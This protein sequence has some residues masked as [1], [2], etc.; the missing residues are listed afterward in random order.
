MNRNSDHNPVLLKL[1]CFLSNSLL[2]VSGG[3]ESGMSILTDLGLTDEQLHKL[4]DFVFAEWSVDVPL[5]RVANPREWSMMDIPRIKER[6]QLFLDDMHMQAD[7]ASIPGV[8]PLN[9][10][11]LDHAVRQLATVGW[12]ARYIIDSAKAVQSAQAKLKEARP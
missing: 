10:A 8:S 4:W 11:V 7:P 3:I 12:L 1:H 5:D 2:V 9:R 6:V